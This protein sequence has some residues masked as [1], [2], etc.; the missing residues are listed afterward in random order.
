[1]QNSNIS[2]L[3]NKFSEEI[4]QISE[5]IAYDYEEL[6][7]KINII[8]EYDIDFRHTF[9]L[10]KLDLFINIDSLDDLKKIKN[11]AIGLVDN[12]TKKNIIRFDN[13]P[14]HN[15]KPSVKKTNPPHHKHI[16]EN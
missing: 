3:I 14:H 1:M 10:E 4:E 13:E 7:T 11:Y 12:N 6:M 8:E 5:K 9:G 16:G 15:D 2:T